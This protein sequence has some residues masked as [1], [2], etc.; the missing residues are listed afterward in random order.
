MNEIVYIIYYNKTSKLD[1]LIDTSPAYLGLLQG[2]REEKF[3]K[4]EIV[5]VKR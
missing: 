3:P 2:G 5:S 4:M 1:R